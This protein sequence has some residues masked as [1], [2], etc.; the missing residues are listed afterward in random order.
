MPST[1]YSSA[2]VFN[3]HFIDEQ[4]LVYVS[5]V[6]CN[7]STKMGTERVFLYKQKPSYIFLQD[8]RAVKMILFSLKI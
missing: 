7:G 5:Q 1:R 3:G 2:V 4:I 6:H 8:I